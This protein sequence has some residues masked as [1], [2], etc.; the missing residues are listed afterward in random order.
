MAW[1]CRI[2][3]EDGEFKLKKLEK[4]AVSKRTPMMEDILY[5]DSKGIG[6][7]GMFQYADSL[8][9]HDYLIGTRFVLDDVENFKMNYHLTKEEILEEKR[10][11]VKY[12]SNQLYEAQ[13]YYDRQEEEYKRLCRQ[14]GVDPEQ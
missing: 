9:K 4:I 3:V 2:V 1:I 6:T 11:K 7:Q 12:A 14:L 5:K 8:T 13:A 10:K